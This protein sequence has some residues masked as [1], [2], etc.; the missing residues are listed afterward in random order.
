MVN[1]SP[2]SAGTKGIQTR[3]KLTENLVSHQNASIVVGNNAI[4]NL[5]EITMDDITDE[6]AYWKLKPGMMVGFSRRIWGHKN[7]YKVIPIK[8]RIFLL[9]FLNNE[10][11]Y[12]I[13]FLYL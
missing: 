10:T 12:L 5:V 2:S 6:F 9:C 3:H 11:Y 1:G 8:K 7:I 4:G 13:T